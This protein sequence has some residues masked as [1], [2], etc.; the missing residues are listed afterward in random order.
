[1]ASRR[2]PRTQKQECERR[3]LGEKPNLN[4]VGRTP[5]HLLMATVFCTEKEQ[6]IDCCHY[7][8]YWRNVEFQLI[9]NFSCVQ[10]RGSNDINE[11]HAR[12]AYEIGAQVLNGIFNIL[13]E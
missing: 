10:L 5:S 4:L 11:L 7:C 13:M 1:M 2:K 9:Q 12:N 6:A 8:F 3:E